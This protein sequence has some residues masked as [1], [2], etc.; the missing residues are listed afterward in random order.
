MGDTNNR[1]AMSV[2]DQIYRGAYDLTDVYP[3][4]V[5]FGAVPQSAVGELK[6]SKDM[7][8]YF[9]PTGTQQG[10]DDIVF[11]PGGTTA[12]TYII[13]FTVYD[14]KGKD[15]PG[16]LTILVERNIGAMDVICITE[17]GE[18]V[19]LS[20][21]QFEKFWNYTYATGTLTQI[22]FTELPSIKEGTLYYDYVSETKPGEMVTTSDTFVS[23][24]S[25]AR[26][27]L[28]DGLTFVPNKKFSGHI[29]IPFDA[30]GLTDRNRNAHLSGNLSV[31]VCEGEAAEITYSFTNGDIFSLDGED[32][33]KIHQEITKTETENM[34]IKVLNV[35]ENGELYLNY[36]GTS[37][38]K[39][40][41]DAVVSEYTFY[42]ST[43]MGDEIDDLTYVSFEGSK[44]TEDILCYVACDNKGEFQ[45][46]GLLYLKGKSS[47]KV[48]TKFFAD[49]VKSP[50]TEWYYTPV[51]DLAE[52]GVINGFEEEVNGVMTSLYKPGGE[53]TYAQALK[54]IMR[55]T[56]YTEPAK[57]G[58]HWAS[59]YLEMAKTDGLIN[60]ALDESYLDRKISRN[61]I[62]QIAAKAMKL[63]DSKLTESPFV[64]VTVGSTYA[65][66]IFALYD[67]G[68]VMGDNSSGNAKYYG[69]NSIT[70]AEMAVIVW[71]IN[72]YSK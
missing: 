43:N 7:P 19:D 72:N 1:T 32:F 29:T 30:Y 34:S 3:E 37:K 17:K 54:L 68:I 67:A 8:Y 69:V 70:R 12:G 16:V 58:S 40:L 65:P 61:V 44:A 57:T 31:F 21:E 52:A 59:G 39:P 14:T 49:I 18:P 62:A 27:S 41:T 64:D 10:M 45:Y 22:N 36:K 66:Y 4:Y 48:Y 5:V 35:P 28:I 2:F 42:Y 56:G 46:I 25:N 26:Q 11:V 9:E 23:V 24:F 6:V 47:V 20:A 51:M 33:L 38:D 55:A 50:S 53:V 15:Y 13:N 60:S 71:R 63:P